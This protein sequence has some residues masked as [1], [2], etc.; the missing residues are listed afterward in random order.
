MPKITLDPRTK[1]LM[2]LLIILFTVFSPTLAQEITMI[3]LIAVAAFLHRAYQRGLLFLAAYAG[4][5]VILALCAT[6]PNTAGAILM[7]IC[8]VLC[9]MLPAV[10]FAF[11]VLLKTK[12]SSLITG[13]QRMKIP[14]KITITLAAA[15][16]FIPTA[17]EENRNIRDAM[18]LRGIQ[19]GPKNLITRPGLV[20][21]GAIIPLM[22]RSAVIA[23]ELSASSVTRGLDSGRK[24]TSIEELRFRPIDWLCLAAF[25]LPTALHLLGGLRK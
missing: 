21:E 13:M 22:L 10:M 19:A 4:L 14:Q 24:R 12:I 20:L 8:A 11:C 2:L 1:M 9:K 3:A 23:E 25:F 18:K 6:H 16:R 15:L 7:M 5:R 17:L